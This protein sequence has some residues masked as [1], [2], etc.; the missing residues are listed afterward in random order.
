[1][2]ASEGEIDDWERNKEERGVPC[3]QRQQH[4][5]EGIL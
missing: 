2:E 5:V 1:M 3:A 4:R